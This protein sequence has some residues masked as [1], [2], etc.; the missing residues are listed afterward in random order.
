M[1]SLSHHVRF[2]ST[3]PFLPTGIVLRDYQ[4]EAIQSVLKY[5]DEGHR[6]LGISLATGA[7]KTVRDAFFS[8]QA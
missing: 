1:L 7:G 5:L 4:E 8:Y 2:N 6:R 3:K